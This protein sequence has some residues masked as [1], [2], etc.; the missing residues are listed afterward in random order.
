MLWI[1][2]LAYPGVGAKTASKLLRQYG[3]LEETLAHADEIK[4]KLGE[5][6]R[7]NAELGLLSKK[8]GSDYS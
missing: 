4:G 7:D 8:A 2:F 3:S 6:I 5:K 1:I